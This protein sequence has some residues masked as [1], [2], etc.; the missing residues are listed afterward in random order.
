MSLLSVRLEHVQH[1]AS[2][3]LDLDLTSHGLMCLV[4]R[5]GAGKTT[6]VRAL[7]NL[8]NAD[9]FIKTATPYAFS[10]HSR[11]SYGLDGVEIAFTYDNRI[12]SLNCRD[13]IPLDLR[14][15]I[16]A[17]LPMPHGTRFNYFKSASEADLDI[18]KSIALGDYQHPA[19]LVAF[20]NSVYDCSRYSALAEVIVK[21]K[22]YYALVK[23][24]G[25]YIR[26]DYLSSGEYFLINLYRTIKG[27][28]KLLVIDEIDLSLDAAAQANLPSWLRGFCEIYGCKLLFTTHSLALMRQLDVDELF[29][30]DAVDGEVSVRPTSYSF[31]MAKLFGFE[32]RDRYILTEDKMLV[33]FIQHLV[34]RYCPDTLLQYKTIFI[35]GAT[36]VAALMKGNETEHFLA[37]PDK[38]IAIL[39]ADQRNVDYVSHPRI[40]TIPL[41]SVEEAILIASREDPEFPFR[42]PRADFTKG[43][44]FNHYLKQ[45][46]IATQEQI[47]DYLI[48]KNEVAFNGIAGILGEFLPAPH[49]GPI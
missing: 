10:T 6:L 9:T 38:V 17:E 13:S 34:G 36:Q 4:G 24:D 5:N 21:G 16:A 39:D 26:E 37:P 14:A 33:A 46:G 44:D 32:G 49:A 11:I 15:L 47:F 8:A 22:S 45:K 18:R 31:A 23:E 43:K 28:A 25:T 1:V 3:R 40:H 7:R 41:E 42:A 27:P 35:G 20:L 48:D 29:Y 19:E 30:M 2:L 12:R